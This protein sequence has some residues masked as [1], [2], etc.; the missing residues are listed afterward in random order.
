MLLHSQALQDISVEVVGELGCK[1]STCLA[2]IYVK[3]S[4]EVKRRVMRRSV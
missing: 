2:A 3:N 1:G 4:L